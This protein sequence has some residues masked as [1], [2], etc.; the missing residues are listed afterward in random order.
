[1]NIVFDLNDADPDSNNIRFQLLQR[2]RIVRVNGHRVPDM[3]YDEPTPREAERGVVG[4]LFI[5]NVGHG[6]YSRQ[7]LE[8]AIHLVCK[9][10][11]I[12]RGFPRWPHYP[13]EQ[14][15]SSHPFG[16]Y[17][18]VLGG[19]GGGYRWHRM[20]NLRIECRVR[21]ARGLLPP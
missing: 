8:S 3:V 20:R 11:A 7:D 10:V 18:V 5:A 6:F 14:V 1:M 17:A 19:T 9:A 21:T 13:G 4:L 15:E 12:S 16:P 2:R